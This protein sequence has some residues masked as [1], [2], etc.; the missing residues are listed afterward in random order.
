LP[1]CGLRLTAEK[2]LP[3]AYPR[4]LKTIG[5]HIR[6]RRLDLGLL[7]KEVAEQIGVDKTTIMNWERGRNSPG[8]QNL[9]GTIKCL[10]YVPSELGQSP[11]D[12]L[13]AVPGG[14]REYPLRK[15][16]DML[17]VD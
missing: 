8:L 17:R 6:K 4:E 5:D 15:L 9:P 12:W 14:F 16:R 1:F 3:K 7:Q 13:R 10:G 2:P 11:P